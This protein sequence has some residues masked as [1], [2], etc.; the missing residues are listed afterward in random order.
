MLFCPGG[1]EL[2]VSDALPPT[3]SSGKPRFAPLSVNWIEPVGVVPRSGAAT[4]AVKVRGFP[5]T[6]GLADE[7]T[8]TVVAPGNATWSISA[9]FW[10]VSHTLPSGP[11]VMPQAPGPNSLVGTGN[12]E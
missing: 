4:A 10:L 12:R 1:S 6:T 2:V 5:C 8:A 7:M 9:G 3:R 11:A